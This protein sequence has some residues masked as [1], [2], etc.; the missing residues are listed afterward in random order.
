MSNRGGGLDFSQGHYTDP[1]ASLQQTLGAG[2]MFAKTLS[3]MQ[4]FDQDQQKM[5]MMRAD[6]ERQ[7]KLDAENKAEKDAVKKTNADNLD[8]QR[9]MMDGQ[10]KYDATDAYNQ[11]EQQGGSKFKEALF[12]GDAKADDMQAKLGDTIV[13]E[14]MNNKTFAPSKMQLANQYALEHGGRGNLNTHQLALISS[15]EDSAVQAKA[16]IQEKKDAL[17]SQEQTYVASG[18]RDEYDRKMKLFDLEARG[19]ESDATIR[20]ASSSSS[21]GTP[22]SDKF[23]SGY[24]NVGNSIYKDIRD[25]GKEVKDQIAITLKSMQDKNINPAMASAAITRGLEL[26]PG[27]G[28]DGI[29]KQYKF[30]QPDV[31]ALKG[32]S[33]EERLAYD[34]GKNGVDEI[35]YAENRKL[36]DGL[37][38]REAQLIGQGVGAND[39]QI[40]DV[41]SKIAKLDRSEGQIYHDENAAT[42][43]KF[44]KDNMDGYVDPAIAQQ[45]KIDKAVGMVSTKVPTSTKT[46]PSSG[47]LAGSPIIL[48]KKKDS[49]LRNFALSSDYNKMDGHQRSSEIQYQAFKLIDSRE[50]TKKDPYSVYN[51]SLGKA[52]V[53]TGILVSGLNKY[54]GHKYD[55]KSIQDRDAMISYSGEMKNKSIKDAYSQAKELGF[56]ADAIPILASVNYQ[57]GSGWKTEFKQSYALLKKGDYDGAISNLKKS[58][59][60]DQ[61]KNRVDDFV[62]AIEQQKAF[63]KSGMLD[64]IKRS[65]TSDIKS[66]DVSFDELYGRIGKNVEKS[67]ADIKNNEYLSENTRFFEHPMSKIKILGDAGELETIARRDIASKSYLDTVKSINVIKAQLSSVPN[68]ISTLPAKKRVDAQNKIDSYNKML[69]KLK[70][71]ESNNNT[72]GGDSYAEKNG[73]PL[74]SALYQPK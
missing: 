5:D 59:W 50:G 19:L 31:S 15:I 42:W 2:G 54:L 1:M 30:S 34:G 53:G 73:I 14:Y 25:S 17:Q 52:T 29:P 20:K 26:V 57:L 3:N 60:N 11:L 6:R 18:K 56:S 16:L 41:R 28:I 8:M 24:G 44:L 63:S 21:D 71:Y 45:A 48:D 36:R 10:S 39:S 46:P 67:S 32:M 49:V 69:D 66:K 4:Q 72:V 22:G 68:D 37:F 55:P 64:N 51:D 33:A 35:A 40:A 43:S 47:T 23:N 62:E 12:K 70:Q 13:N 27:T 9:Y 74:Y 7:A 61:T 65:S 38:A 58:D